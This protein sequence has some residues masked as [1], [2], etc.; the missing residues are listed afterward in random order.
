MYM[1]GRESG[2]EAQLP[3]GHSDSDLIAKV[4]MRS[5]TF[6]LILT[7]DTS[8]EF[9]RSLVVPA[10]PQTPF[11]LHKSLVVVPGIVSIVHEVHVSCSGRLGGS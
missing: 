6:C 11:R 7:V 5:Q 9:E 10:L 2:D 4:E 3:I 1:Q 8:E